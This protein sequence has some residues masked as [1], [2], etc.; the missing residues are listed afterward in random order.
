MKIFIDYSS[1]FR[2]SNNLSSDALSSLLEINCVTICNVVVNGNIFSLKENASFRIGIIVKLFKKWNAIFGVKFEKCNHLYHR[3][4]AI[5]WMNRTQSCP[6]CRLSSNI[7][8]DENDNKVYVF[9]QK[10]KEE[11]FDSY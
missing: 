10:E 6:T 9:V 4:C 3:Q 8:L 7:L 2:V 5:E 11:E 1:A